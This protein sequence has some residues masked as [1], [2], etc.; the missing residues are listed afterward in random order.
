MRTTL[1][2][3][4]PWKGKHLYRCFLGQEMIGDLLEILPA[5]GDGVERNF[6]VL[7]DGRVILLSL[8]EETLWIRSDLDVEEFEVTHTPSGRIHRICACSDAT[9]SRLVA[10]LFRERLGG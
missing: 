10:E 6:R 8:E 1:W 2:D 3:K 9:R 7:P 4:R 5:P